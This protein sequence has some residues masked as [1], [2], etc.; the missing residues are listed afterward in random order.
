MLDEAP[1][2]DAATRRVIQSSLCV[3]HEEAL[4]D[5]LVDDNE[6]QLGS[7]T[8]GSLLLW[9]QLVDSVLELGDLNSDDLVTLGVAD[10]IPE[11]DE[12]GGQGSVVPLLEGFNCELERLL[13]P[14]VHDFLA[15]SL[16]QV[17]RVV[18]RHRWVGRG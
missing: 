3:L 14:G 15:A 12:V 8:R 4:I 2:D 16:H 6:G 18:L 11:D 17:L 10:T 13:E 5:P 7:G 9:V 1:V